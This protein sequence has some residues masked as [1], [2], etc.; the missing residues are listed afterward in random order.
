MENVHYLYPLKA[1]V[2]ERDHN[3]NIRNR[4]ELSH[5][6]IEMY[7]KNCLNSI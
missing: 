6:S 5:V 2:I 7:I 4:G 1:I 3:G